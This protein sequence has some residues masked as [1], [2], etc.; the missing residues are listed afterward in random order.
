MAKKTVRKRTRS[1]TTRPRSGRSAIATGAA[2][3]QEALR[4]RNA[5]LR[6][7]AAAM[8]RASPRAIARAAAAPSALAIRAAGVPSPLGTLLAEGD[9]WF[10]YPWNDVLK[11]LEEDHGFDVESVAHMG[12]NVEDMAYSGRQFEDFTERLDK[13]LRHGTVPRAILLSGGGNDLAGSEFHMLLDHVL[14][15]APG[16]NADVARGVIDVRI[17]NAY[18]T[19]ISAM[20][21]LCRD[22]A[23]AILP[24]VVHGYDRPVPDGRGFLFGPFPGPWLKPG[25]D[26]KGFQKADLDRTTAMIGKLIDQFNRMLG[27]VAALP[28]FTHVHYVDLRGTLSNTAGYRTWWANELHPTGTGFAAVADKFATVISAL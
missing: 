4:L 8:R 1:T 17:R 20:T 19:L 21:T 22:R 18:T 26:R 2:L 13:M 24:I 23:G 28:Q 10:D 5:S 9:S 12:D 25:F 6:K 11:K 3:A 15:P 7:R 14:S 16:V 27:E